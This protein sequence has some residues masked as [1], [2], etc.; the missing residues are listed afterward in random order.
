MSGE[1]KKGM[2]GAMKGG[3][4]LVA[5][6]ILIA[7]VVAFWYASK[8]PASS[9][10]DPT[11]TAEAEDN[12]PV[13]PAP[14]ALGGSCPC[15]EGM[16]CKDGKCYQTCV[17]RHNCADGEAPHNADFTCN[18]DACIP[19]TGEKM[20]NI[21]I[22]GGSQTGPKSHL[23]GWQDNPCKYTGDFMSCA[24][25]K[26]CWEAYGKGACGGTTEYANCGWNGDANTQAK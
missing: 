2:S 3:I 13:G 6:V 25:Y 21:T 19:G 10:T 4:A 12:G 15:G 5:A 23:Y 16:T 1:N 7:I 22:C 18:Y 9:P 20:A 24:E 14:G 17:A 26:T 8:T 11:A